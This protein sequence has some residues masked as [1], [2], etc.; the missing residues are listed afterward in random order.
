[1]TNQHPRRIGL[2]VKIVAGLLVIS[3]VPLAVS[4]WAIDGIAEVSQMYASNEAARLR[5][6]VMRAAPVYRQLIETKKALYLQT[7]QRYAASREV[8]AMVASQQDPAAAR[9]LDDMLAS[10]PELYRA[11]VLSGTGEVL[12]ER[13]HSKPRGVS[14]RYSAK[15]MTAPIA[16]TDARLRLTFAADN[17]LISELEDLGAQ[18]DQF[19]HVDRM[20]SSLPAGYRK[21]FLIAVG[22]VVL[23]VTLAGILLSLWLTRRIAILVQGTR[24]VAAGDLESRVELRGRDELGEL[25]SAFNAM[26]DDIDHDRQQI[27]YLQRVGAWQD[28]ARKLAHEIKNPLTPIQLA[29]QQCVSSYKGD[30][31]RYQRLLKDAEEIV[32]EEIASLRRLVDAFRT[33]GQLPQVE[34][35][36]L[37]LGTIMDDLMRDPSL[38]AQLELDEPPEAVRV[39]AD[40]LLLRRVLTNLVENGQQAGRQIGREGKVVVTWRARAGGVRAEITVD[41]EGPGIKPDQRDKIFEPYVTSKET[42]TGLGLTIS[43][44][45]ALEHGGSLDVA[46][47]PSPLGGARFRLVLPLSDGEEPPARA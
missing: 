31:E 39:R 33:L 1:V 24:R 34:A 16:G 22:G 12:I 32:S 38:L 8:S 21:S 42:G 28:V 47:E 25:A 27:A 19:K 17:S 35:E 45:I 30:D 37:D 18:I 41:D 9:F 46:P 20:R 2:Q 44:K 13:V 11:A 29:V 26:L 10:V 43:K 40:R 7:T 14:E 5:Q 23:L 6:P 15:E 4:A 36:P 3:M